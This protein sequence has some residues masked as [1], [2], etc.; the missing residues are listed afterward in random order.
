MNRMFVVVAALCALGFARGFA[1][2]VPVPFGE[3][4]NTSF[5]DAVDGDKQGDC[6]VAAA[7]GDD[8]VITPMK[9]TL[10]ITRKFTAPV[11]EA[12]L[13]QQKTDKPPRNIILVIGDG[14]GQGAYDLTSLWT[15]GETNRLVMQQLPVA[16]LSKT[17]SKSS[18]VTDSAAAATAMA[19]GMKVNNANIGVTADGK[20]LK[21]VAEAARARGKSIA[22]IT[23][24]SISGA[25]PACFFAHQSARGMAPE[26]VA[27]AAACGFEIIIGD[28]G[29][30]G[31]FMQNGKVPDQHNLQKEMES[32]GYRFISTP[33]AFAATPGTNKVLGQIESKIFTENDTALSVF[34]KTAIDRLEKDADGFFMMVESTYPDKG[35]HANDPT[36]ST[37]GTVHAD[38][39]AKVAVEYAAAHGDTLVICTADHETGSL[40]VKRNLEG[41]LDIAYGGISHSGAKV[42][43][44]A[45]G[46]GAELFRGETD[47]T[48]IARNIAKLWDFEIPVVGDLSGCD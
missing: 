39:V 12:P 6:M 23:S 7:A 35:G 42:P 22:L 38:W 37:M 25:T 14:M 2:V 21:S 4:A 19:C 10:K 36:V 32:R 43:I 16:G 20:R 24:D 30:R 40:S 44:Y 8:K 46:P 31:L 41:G 11:L 26:I 9:S 28:A 1:A 29:T 48:E 33:E 17:F 5:T 27:D 3:A 13:V 15:H 45:F 47:N 34:S 18:S